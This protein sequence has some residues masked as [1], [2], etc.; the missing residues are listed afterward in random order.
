L[1]GVLGGILLLVLA[2]YEADASVL[3]ARTVSETARQPVQGEPEI[4]RFGVALQPQDRLITGLRGQADVDIDR[5]GFLQLGPSARLSLERVPFASYARDLR[6]QLRLEEGYLRVVWKHPGL[7]QEWPIVIDLASFR[8]HLTRGEFFFQRRGERL[9]LC[10]ADGAVSVTSVGQSSPVALP[11]AACYRLLPGAAPIPVAQSDRA[12]VEVREQRDLTA[13]ALRSGLALGPSLGE[14]P[15]PTPRPPPL[16]FEA[17]MTASINGQPTPPPRPEPSPLTPTP[18]PPLP[19]AFPT[20]APAAPA[21]NG[22]WGLNLASL[23][24]L[25]AAQALQTQLQSRG[26]AATI[27][28][29][30]IRGRTWYHVQLLGLPDDAAARA[31]AERFMRDTGLT[32]VWVLK[33]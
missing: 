30:D 17:A 16:T 32:G 5:H 21:G 2:V 22:A 15:A 29:A 19:T 14:M 7:S 33:P 31:L 13:L 23:S 4:L 8:V 24:S 25:E 10:I 18:P 1:K 11:A 27:T 20:Y 3:L 6:T 12:F 26:Y 28:P 9:L